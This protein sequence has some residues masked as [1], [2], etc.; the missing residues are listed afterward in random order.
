MD[1]LE[2]QIK[3]LKKMQKDGKKQ[4]ERVNA[5]VQKQLLDV[6]LIDQV[7]QFAQ[8]SVNEVKKITVKDRVCNKWRKWRK[9]G[10]ILVLLI[11]VGFLANALFRRYK[12]N[13]QN[14][15]DDSRFNFIDEVTERANDTFDFDNASLEDLEE[16]LL[17]I[18]N[19]LNE[20]TDTLNENE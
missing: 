5:L 11:G 15:E 12:K 4:I 8:K 19:D 13:K 17:R 10:M 6:E 3:K 2:V 14:L 1:K 9:A 16:A 20:V 18:E 7:T